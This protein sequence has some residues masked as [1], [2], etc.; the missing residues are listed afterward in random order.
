MNTETLSE[1]DK[2]LLF[3]AS[4]L[5]LLAAGVSFVFRVMIP[6][7]WAEEFQITMA[8][9]GALT[10]TALWPIAV[11]MILFSLL[12][13]KIGYKVSM[14]FAFAFQALSVVLTIT[15]SNSGGMWWACFCAGLGH[16]VVEAVI[17]PL[18][19]SAYRSQKSKWLNILHAAWPAGIVIGGIAYILLVGTD[20]GL[21]WSDAKWIF[22][23]MLLPVI[24]Y[25]VLF[26]ICKRF[27]VDER[28]EAGIS[29]GDMMKEFGGLGIFLASTFL[30]YELTGQL[31]IDLGDS[32]LYILSLIHI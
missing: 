30:L 15:A 8:E 12:V 32:K 2:N 17:N 6:S 5:S 24:A 11:T 20:D 9:V 23:F 10:G 25:G 19:A 13:D 4:F 26:F 3:W 21:K 28:V 31:Q 16:G 14:F 29:Y 27:P 22:W 1:R 18:C 7:M